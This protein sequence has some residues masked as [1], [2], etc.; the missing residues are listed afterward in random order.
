MMQRTAAKDDGLEMISKKELAALLS[1]NSWTLDRWRKS[2]PEFPRAVW[3]S[4]TTPRWRKA[5]VERWLA[6]RK[7]GGVAPDWENRTKP[8][9]AKP[10]RRSPALRNR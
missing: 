7:T 10:S 6:T 3:L 4:P 1:V 5:D 8:R 2:D 9:N